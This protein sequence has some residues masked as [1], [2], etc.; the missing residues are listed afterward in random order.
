MRCRNVHQFRLP[1]AAGLLAVVSLPIANYAQIVQ[2][3]HGVTCPS[4]RVVTEQV[5]T[6]G[7][8]DTTVRLATN[9]TL[10]RDSRGRYFAKTLDNY[11]IVVWDSTGRRVGMLD[12]WGSRPGQIVG[13]ID[14]ILLDRR[15]SLFVFDSSLRISVFSPSLELVRTVAVPIRGRSVTLLSSGDFLIAAPTR[16]GPT[17][18]DFVR[19]VGRDTGAVTRSFV[20]GADTSVPVA[21]RAVTS[22]LALASDGASIWRWTSYD[23]RLE[24]WNADGTAAEVLDLAAAPWYRP[25]AKSF[26]PQINRTKDEWRAYVTARSS[27]FKA[28]RDSLFAAEMGGAASSF[29]VAGIDRG[30]RLWLAGHEPWAGGD[31]EEIKFML[32]IVDPVTRTKFLSTSIAENLTLIPGTELAYSR[33]VER[34]NG[35]PVVTITVWR[36]RIEGPRA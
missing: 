5:L 4:C 9:A 31:V 7:G 27:P 15:D 18:G 25:R 1:V 17:A 3:P 8:S 14:E 32:E 23:Y 11:S 21:Q 16:F 35:T 19:I 13:T 2:V 33:R 22:W 30:G 20:A 24:R 36:V 29:R 34:V 6:F 26:Q 28:V 12:R 10:L